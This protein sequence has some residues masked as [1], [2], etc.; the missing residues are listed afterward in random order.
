MLVVLADGHRRAWSDEVLDAI[1][2]S[3]NCWSMA[4]VAATDHL[5]ARFNLCLMDFPALVANLRAA[6]QDL[7]ARLTSQ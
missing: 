6:E 2:P 4:P 5:A 7:A 3:R 1:R